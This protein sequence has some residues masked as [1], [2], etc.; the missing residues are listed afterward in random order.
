MSKT[1]LEKYY[2]SKAALEILSKEVEEMRQEVI[3]HL[4]QLPGNKA[5]LP[6]AKFSLRKDYD[7]AFSQKVLEQETQAKPVIDEHKLAIKQQQDFIK[8]MKAQEIE[9]GTAEVVDTTY[10]PVM[11]IIKK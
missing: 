5:E 7:Y 2:E 8:K 10:I 11:T 9:D 6:N 1:I 4:L 3:E